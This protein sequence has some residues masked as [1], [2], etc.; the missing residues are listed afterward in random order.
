MAPKRTAPRTTSANYDAPVEFQDVV[1]GRR[2]V[3][4]FDT[5]PTPDPARDRI[6][7]NALHAPSAGFS[8][9]WAFM[10]FEGAE[11]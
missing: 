5:T 2:M 9:G 1:R 6:L 11:T 4:N 8:Q 3:R 7:S 10:T